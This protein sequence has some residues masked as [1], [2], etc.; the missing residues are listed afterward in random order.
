LLKTTLDLDR[1]SGLQKTHRQ[2]P[3]PTGA[4]E[5]TYTERQ[6][7]AAIELEVLDWVKFFKV[8][9]TVENLEQRRRFHR[10]NL[11]CNHLGELDQYLRIV[12]PPRHHVAKTYIVTVEHNG[13]T[14]PLRGTIWEAS[15]DRAQHFP[16]AEAAQAALGK[17]KKF[18]RPALRRKARIV[19]AG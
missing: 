2:M 14:W 18:M 4:T 17:A 7:A 10:A 5:M 15:M 6:I 3:A 1:L 11:T 13:E 16:S 19:E 9:A 8:E 12:A